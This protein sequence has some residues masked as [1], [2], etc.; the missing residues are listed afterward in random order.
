MEIF[1]ADIQKL[2]N[3][4]IENFVLHIG[5]AWKKASEHD[6][7]LLE[8]CAKDAAKLHFKT[9]TSKED[10]RKEILIVNASLANLSVAIYIQVNKIFWESVM[11]AAT[12]VLT[13]FIRS[14]IAASVI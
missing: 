12:I 14:A 9:L 8:Q 11:R 5:D 1:D 6:K 13:T 4:I 2:K 7:K 3:E 10:L